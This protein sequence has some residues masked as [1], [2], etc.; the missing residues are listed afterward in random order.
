MYQMIQIHEMCIKL[1]H[2]QE[3]F[4]CVFSSWITAFQCGNQYPRLIIEVKDEKYHDVYP[5][6]L[7]KYEISELEVFST[8][9]S[10]RISS[11]RN[12]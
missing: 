12:L 3:L 1:Q 8:G 7:E 11:W 10:S 4:L 2:W 9:T 6:A 5:L